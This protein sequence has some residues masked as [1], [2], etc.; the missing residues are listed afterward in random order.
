[1][2]LLRHRLCRGAPSSTSS[3]ISLGASYIER[4]SSDGDL[5]KTGSLL[6]HIAW[7]FLAVTLMLLKDPNMCT[8]WSATI[9]LVRVAFSIACR[10]LPPWPAMRPIARLGCW[11]FVWMPT[12]Q[13]I[14]DAEQRH[15]TTTAATKTTTATTTTTTAVTTTTTTAATT[16]ST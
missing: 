14:D 10:V 7:F 2:P 3:K 13:D 15:R 11:F 1:M 9:I 8:F 16:T 6:P 12:R 4:S 5:R